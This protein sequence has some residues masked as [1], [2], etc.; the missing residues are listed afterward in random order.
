[1]IWLIL[2]CINCDID[3]ARDAGWRGEAVLGAPASFSSWRAEDPRRFATRAACLAAIRRERPAHGFTAPDQYGQIDATRHHSDYVEE[4]S[5][6]PL[7]MNA[8]Q[9]FACFTAPAGS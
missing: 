8:S 7:R 4:F 5:A 3:A 2:V 6:I 1:M 9:N